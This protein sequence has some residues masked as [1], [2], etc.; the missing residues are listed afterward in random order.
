MSD[1]KKVWDDSNLRL[2][3]LD[4][5]ASDEATMKRIAIYDAQCD[6][7]MFAAKTARAEG[8]TQIADDLDSIANECWGRVTELAH[9]LENAP[10]KKLLRD[11]AEEHPDLLDMMVAQLT[12]SSSE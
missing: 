10:R 5:D 9:D 8:K 1:I 7:M 2:A 6:L 12:D 4:G 11:F 3:I